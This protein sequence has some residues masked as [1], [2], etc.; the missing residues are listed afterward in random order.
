M[1]RLPAWPPPPGIVR[2]ILGPDPDNP[3]P[4][5]PAP[6]PWDLCA[7][8]GDLETAVW[9]W[10]D[11]VAHW[12]NTTYGHTDGHVIPGCWP[13]HPAIAHELAAIAFTRIEVYSASTAA[14]IPRWHADLDD[15]HRR[16]D[17]SLGPNSPCG[18]V[19]H[20]ELPERYAA[21]SANFII[22]ERLKN[23]RPR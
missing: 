2:R 22:G 7:L 18:R 15:F 4:D 13:H 12:L 3:P 10:L 20:D 9:T 17:T 21:I 11:H 14:Y 19:R 5:E 6:N 23:S 16:M 1:T 8:T